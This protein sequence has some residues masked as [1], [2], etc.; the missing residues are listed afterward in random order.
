MPRFVENGKEM[1]NLHWPANHTGFIFP[2]SLR[3]LHTIMEM[4]LSF[5]TILIKFYR[6][7]ASLLV[8]TF[9][10]SM[11]KYRYESNR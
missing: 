1:I 10:Y 6:L 7:S 9:R 4:K 2:F 8:L 11:I 5:C 3:I